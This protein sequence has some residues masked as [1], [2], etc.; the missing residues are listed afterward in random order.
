M[1]PLVGKGMMLPRS[2]R[3]TLSEVGQLIW[4]WWSLTLLQQFE[5]HPDVSSGLFTNTLKDFADYA[6]S[7]AAAC[8]PHCGLVSVD[9]THSTGANVTHSASNTTGG[10]YNLRSARGSSLHDNQDKV[11]C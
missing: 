6:W 10:S 8:L 5:T 3:A 4:W 2:C 7:D 9:N 1:L 11:T